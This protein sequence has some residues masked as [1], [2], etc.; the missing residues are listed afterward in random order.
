MLGEAFN[1]RAVTIADDALTRDSVLIIER[2]ERRD[3]EGNRADGRVLEAPEQF[4][5]VLRDT[6]CEL[7]RAS[8]ERRWKLTETSCVPNPGARND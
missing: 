1:G 6:H 7:I 2:R 5:L 3:L 4:R 8:D